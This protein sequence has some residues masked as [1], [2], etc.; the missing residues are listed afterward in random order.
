[1]MNWKSIIVVA[2]F[3]CGASLAQSQVVI[4]EASNRNLT[5]VLDEDGE[6]EDWIELYNNTDSVVNIEGWALSDNRDKPSK[7]VIPNIYLQPNSTHLFFASDKDRSDY[8]VGLNWRTAVMADDLFEYIIPDAS[9]SATWNTLAYDVESWATGQAGFG[10]GDNDDITD[11]AEGTLAVY[12]RKNFIIND[13]SVIANAICHVDYDDGFVAYLNGTEICR[14]NVTGTPSWNS[15]SAGNHNAVGT[16]EAFELDMSLIRSVWKQGE[17]VFALEVHN[18]NTSSS[19]LSLIPYLSFQVDNEST[20]FNAPPSWLLDSDESILHTNFKISPSGEKVFLFSPQQVLVDSL[21]VDKLQLNH[22][23]GRLTDGSDTLAIFSEATPGASNNTSTGYWKGYEKKPDFSLEAGFYSGTQQ[24]V[25]T[26]DSLAAPSSIIRY[27]IDGSTPQSDSKLYTGAISVSSTT[28]VNARCFSV[29]G[30]LAS[31]TRTVSYFIDEDF[32]IPVLSVTTD[33]ENLWGDDGIFTNYDEE[34]NK[35]CYV[36]YFD[37]SKNL[38]FKQ[39]AGIQVDGGAGGSR[40]QPQTSFRVEPGNG[41]FGDGELDYVLLP[42]RPNREIYES[43]YM[44]NGSNRYLDLQYKDASQVKG[45]AKGT[46]TFYSAYRPAI[47]FINGEYYGMYEVREKINVD[48]LESNYNMNTDSIDIVGISHRNGPRQTLP[49]VGTTDSFFADWDKFMALD[50]ASSTYLEDVGELLDIESY[51]DYMAGQTWMT[52][53]DWPH[54]NMKA[55]KCKGNGMRWQFAIMDLEWSFAPTGT[56]ASLKTDPSFDQIQYMLDNGTDYQASGYWYQLMQNTEYKNFFINRLSDLMN[57][58]YAY[59]V[60]SEIET[61]MFEEMLPEV[62][63]Y[64]ERWG[65]D[66][67]SFV[68]NHETFNSELAK[69]TDYLRAHLQ[70]HYDLDNQIDIVLDVLPKGSGKIK[71]S[72]IIPAEYPWEGIYFSDVPITIEAIANPGYAFKSWD[73]NKYISDITAEVFTTTIADLDV[74]FAANFEASAS[75]FDG[76]TISEIN[77]KDGDEFNTTDWFE[78]WNARDQALSLEGWYFTD[79]DDSHRYDFRSTTSIAAGERLVV[80]KNVDNFKENY[81][82]VYNYTGEFTFGLGTPYDEINLYNNADELVVHVSY[83]DLFPWPLADNTEGFTL[84]LLDP[85][86]S[87]LESGNWFKGCYKGSPGE[88]Y[89]IDCNYDEPPLS[90]SSAVDESQDVKLYPVP[91]HEIVN[92]EF[93]ID[94]NLTATEIRV[95]NVLGALMMTE[96]LDD[97]SSGETI[98]LDISHL[99]PEQMYII[100]LSSAQLQK[101]LKMFKE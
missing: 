3:F 80:V 62:P 22:S 29:E 70:S 58:N 34:W 79:N 25:M 97:I 88:A 44:R 98:Q 64:Y 101:T 83:S 7:W 78:I 68:T 26:L 69:R 87:L 91:A 33:S 32:T 37:V 6:N 71:I 82:H 4:N 43:F 17:N 27:T 12:I 95:Y 40:S 47:C 42:D 46:N 45:M 63:A 30:H 5:Q 86:S 16:P 93:N 60:L 65:G 31:N 1:M 76:V 39:A 41:T 49:I 90:L 61:Q 14:A 54:N 55:W 94:V 24:L 73:D 11:I 18:V 13:T 19:D 52:N 66:V 56:A 99:K 84:E 23:I 72:T 21:D 35:P 57:T 20:D 10:Y 50:P 89:N 2:V 53:R 9:V 85:E 51:T 92:L 59:E 8:A 75:T 77:Y 28:T 48:Y 67:A 96:S 81:P 74:A 15:T 100:R 36:E 38:A